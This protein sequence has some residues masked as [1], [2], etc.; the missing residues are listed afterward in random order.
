MTKARISEHHQILPPG[1]LQPC[2]TP[3]ANMEKYNKF[4]HAVIGIREI[5]TG[6]CFQIHLKASI[7]ATVFILKFLITWVHYKWY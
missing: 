5:P 6:F 7:L 2:K 1:L 4:P 3:C